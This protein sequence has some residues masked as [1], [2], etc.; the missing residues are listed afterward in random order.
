MVP[1]PTSTPATLR[2]RTFLHILP[3]LVNL[4]WN[5]QLNWTGDFI[6]FWGAEYNGAYPF[7]SSLYELFNEPFSTC[8]VDGCLLAAGPRLLPSAW[9]MFAAA[10]LHGNSS[11]S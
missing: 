9:L 3:T 5:D 11:T 7:I 8:D 4:K 10:G 6:P 2:G 1:P